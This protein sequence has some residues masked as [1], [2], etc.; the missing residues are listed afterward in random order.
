MAPGSP[1]KDGPFSPKRRGVVQKGRRLPREDGRSGRSTSGRRAPPGWRRCSAGGAY[2]YF[3]RLP[4]GECCPFGRPS[5]SQPSLSHPPSRP[6]GRERAPEPI[7][8]RVSPS[9]LVR[10]GGRMGEEGRGDE[11]QRTEDAKSDKVKLREP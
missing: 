10:S 7:F 9:Y 11:G 6:D 4:A 3:V 1:E 5:L 8:E 2:L